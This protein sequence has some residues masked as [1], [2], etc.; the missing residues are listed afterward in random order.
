MWRKQPSHFRTAPRSLSSAEVSVQDWA[1]NHPHALETLIGQPL[2]P[3]EFADDRLS[4]VLR[5]LRDADWT[6]LR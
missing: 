5:R 6:A 2:R 1:R 4:I 3:I